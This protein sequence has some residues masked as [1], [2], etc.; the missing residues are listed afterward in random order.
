MSYNIH[1]DLFFNINILIGR[2][3]M[4]I[5]HVVTLLALI[6]SPSVI[7]QPKDDSIGTMVHYLS[8]HNRIKELRTSAIKCTLEA[9]LMQQQLHKQ[10]A[11]QGEIQSWQELASTCQEELRSINRIR[12]ETFVSCV[13]DADPGHDGF[14]YQYFLSN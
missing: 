13:N 12:S 8:T 11:S 7:A 5:L 4:K 9:R 10:G 2:F 1:V 3:E 14:C 6:V